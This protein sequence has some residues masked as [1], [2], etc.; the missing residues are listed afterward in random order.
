MRSGID[1]GSGDAITDAVQSS[2]AAA[3]AAAVPDA[4][5]HPANVEL[6]SSDS[7][8]QLDVSGIRPHPDGNAIV[9]VDNDKTRAVG[10]EFAQPAYSGGLP[11]APVREKEN[12]ASSSQIRTCPIPE[13]LQMQFR[14]QE[15]SD[16]GSLST[17]PWSASTTAESPRM[18][19]EARARR[20]GTVGFLGQATSDPRHSA[21]TF[22]KQPSSFRLS[23]GEF[24]PRVD[25]FA[26]P[27]ARRT[28][29][30]NSS[31]SAATPTSALSTNDTIPVSAPPQ[32]SDGGFLPE[33]E[34]ASQSLSS[35]KSRSRGRRYSVFD[36]SFAGQRAGNSVAPMDNALTV[37]QP[38]VSVAAARRRGSSRGPVDFPAYDALTATSPALRRDGAAVGIESSSILGSMGSSSNIRRNANVSRTHA[39]SLTAEMHDSHAHPPITPTQINTTYDDYA[40]RPDRHQHQ[41]LPQQQSHSSIMT[42][43]THS[44]PSDDLQCV[45]GLHTPTSER[46]ASSSALAG[47]H[48]RPGSHYYH[49]MQPTGARS[50]S[51]HESSSGHSTPTNRLFSKL[52][53]NRS[54]SVKSATA[55]DPGLARK[56]RA[57]IPSSI[58]P[59]TDAMRSPHP[60]ERPYHK[61][62]DL[63][64]GNCAY[65]FG[66]EKETEILHLKFTAS[67]PDILFMPMTYQFGGQTRA[68]K[69]PDYSYE[70]LL[71]IARSTKA[72]RWRWGHDRTQ[73][74]GR[75]DGAGS[76]TK[77]S[78]DGVELHDRSAETQAVSGMQH[79]DI[80]SSASGYHNHR[81]VSEKPESDRLLEP[82]MHRSICHHACCV[83]DPSNDVSWDDWTDRI[84]GHS[85]TAIVQR[86]VA[87]WQKLLRSWRRDHRPKSHSVYH[88]F[89]SAMGSTSETQQI[90]TPAAGA[91][92]RTHGAGGMSDV[93][94]LSPLNS[95]SVGLNP[96]LLE[97]LY[98]Q[99]GVSESGRRSSLN[100][101]AMFIHQMTGHSQLTALLSPLDKPG[102]C[103]RDLAPPSKSGD[104]LPNCDSYSDTDTPALYLPPSSSPA[105]RSTPQISLGDSSSKVPAAIHRRLSIV[106]DQE[107]GR[108]RPGLGIR[109]NSASSQLAAKSAGNSR[110]TG[111]D[112]ALGLPSKQ[113]QREPSTEGSDIPLEMLLLF[114]SRLQSRLGRAKAETE[115]ELLSII[116][117]LS[118]FVEEG[119]SYVHEDMEVGI[120]TNEGDAA[121][122]GFIFDEY[123]HASDDENV[124]TPGLTIPGKALLGEHRRAS[125]IGMHSYARNS[126]GG[127][128]S[129]NPRTHLPISPPLPVKWTS[130][131]ATARVEL[132]SLDRR[133][134]D[135]LDLHGSRSDSR[136]DI[137]PY[138]A[139][140]NAS[141]S[142]SPTDVANLGRAG[143][144]LRPSSPRKA[145]RSPSIRRLAFLKSLSTDGHASAMAASSESEHIGRREKS[146]G[147]LS[148]LPLQPQ[149]PFPEYLAAPGYPPTIAG[150]NTA[151][152]V[153]V[154]LSA[155]CSCQDT[156]MTYAQTVATQRNT[157]PCIIC[158]PKEDV[159]AAD[160]AR[161]HT[162]HSAQDDVTDYF[163][164]NLAASSQQNTEFSLPRGIPFP[165]LQKQR[166]L[167]SIASGASSHAG[168]RHSPARRSGSRASLYSTGSAVSLLSSPL[169]AED[170]FRPTPFLVAIMDLVNIIG[171]VLSLSAEDML[172]PLSGS[173]LNEALEWADRVGEE[174]E[175]VTVLMPTAYLV[176]RLNDLGYQWEHSQVASDQTH[177]GV[178]QLWPCRSLFVQALLA[179]SSLNR[180][181][182]WYQAVCSTY[183]DEDIAELDMHTNSHRDL[184]SDRGAAHSQPMDSTA[185]R[186]TPGSGSASVRTGLS[187]G[188]GSIGLPSVHGSS[189]QSSHSGFPTDASGSGKEGFGAVQNCPERQSNY[190]QRW[191]ECLG[192]PCDDKPAIDSGL[193]MLVEVALDG[194]IRY[195]SPTCRRLL[196]A[197]P[198]TMIDQPAAVMFDVRD[199]ELYRTAVEQLLTDS[200]RTVELNIRVHPPALFPVIRVEAKG[201]L[202]YG[203]LHNEPSHVLWVLRYIS[204]VSEPQSHQEHED[205]SI[206]KLEDVV[207]SEQ[208]QLIGKQN[209]CGTLPLRAV[210]AVEPLAATESADFGDADEIELRSSSSPLEPVTCRICDRNVPATHFE[211]HS[212]LCATSH[213]A[214]M[215]VEQQNERLGDIRTQLQAWFPGCEFE[216][217]EELTHGGIDTDA[218]CDKEKQKGDAVGHPAWQILVDEAA[219]I[220][221][222]MIR[223]C[224]R[225]MSLDGTDA[226]P[227]CVFRPEASGQANSDFAYSESWM[228]MVGYR[229]PVLEFSDP[230][231][232]ELGRSLLQ[233]L[234][235]KQTAVENLQYAIIDSSL[236][237]INWDGAES[238]AEE[239]MMFSDLV[240]RAAAKST[241]DLMDTLGGNRTTP[242]QHIPG[243]ASSE[244]PLR[245]STDTNT[246]CKA[247]GE[248]CYN[249][250]S[251]IRRSLSSYSLTPT[252]QR[253]VGG[254]QEASAS[255][256]D[257]VGG[258]KRMT[259]LPP[260]IQIPSRK[261]S[262]ISSRTSSAF[263]ESPDHS[264]LSRKSWQQRMAGSE[265]QPTSAR[266]PGRTSVSDASILATPT[267]PSIHDFDLLKP[268]SKGAYGSVYLAKKR[269]TGDYYAIKILKKA[270]MIAKN[271]I[272]NVKAERAIMM[273]QSG[274]PFV[275]RL[276]YT[277]QSRTSLYLVMEYLNGGDCAS[278]LKVIGVL[279]EEW[280]RHYL[281][282]VVLGIEDLHARGVVH[283]D[284]KPDNLL[285]D[286][287]GH[288][289][290]TDFGLSKLGFL[291]R[292]VGQQVMPH[293][294]GTHEPLQLSDAHSAEA[295]PDDTYPWPALAG[296]A[297][298][299]TQLRLPASIR[300]AP[301]RS[302]TTPQSRGD[303][304]NR[305]SADD[306]PQLLANKRIAALKEDYPSQSPLALEQI[307]SASGSSASISSSNSGEG[308]NGSAA[309]APAHRK[310]ALGTPD[311]IAPES[312]LGLE[313]GESVDWWALGVICYEFL[314]GVPPF[315]ECTPEK[316][317]ENILSGTI[318]FYDESR[319]KLEHETAESQ[320]AKHASAGIEKPS[321][322]DNEDQDADDEDL[323][324]PD[325]SS[326]A[327]DF[328]TRLLCRDP[329]R[330]LGYHGA[331]EV[332]AHPIFTG[333]N[334]DTLLDKQPAFIPQVE[335]VDDTD[336]FDPRGATMESDH[337]FSDENDFTEAATGCPEGSRTLS[338]SLHDNCMTP[339]LGI[340]IAIRRPKT[341][342]T[343]LD[344]VVNNVDKLSP[345][346][347]ARNNPI[348][349]NGNSDDEDLPKLDDAREFGGFT[350]KNLHALEEANMN[351]L[352]KL[353]RR[354]TLIGAPSHFVHRD[355]QRE[356][357]PV[358]MASDNS[359][360][361][362]ARRN[363]SCL[364]RSTA[365]SPSVYTE[366]YPIQR[367]SSLSRDTRQRSWSNMAGQPQPLGMES[368]SMESGTPYQQ[369]LGQSV[370]A[371]VQ[372]ART[373]TLPLISPG[374]RPLTNVNPISV[375]PVSSTLSVTDQHQMPLQPG[376]TRAASTNSNRG[377]LLNPKVQL[378]R[379]RG[380]EGQP[381]AY[382]SND[383]ALFFDSAGDQSADKDTQSWLP[384]P[385]HAP[386]FRRSATIA[387]LHHAEYSP[388][389][390]KASADG[391]KALHHS[392][393]HIKSKICLVADDN[394][395]CCKIM[396]IILQ[397]MHMGCV[398]VRNGAE[399]IRCIMGCT[400]Y[401][402]IFM[403]TGMPI[404]DGDEATRMVKS[405]YNANKDT[406][407]FAMAAYED[408]ANRALY[409]G[410]LVKPVTARQIKQLLNYRF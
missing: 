112:A 363:R 335:N 305:Y 227:Q 347:P 14:D 21:L 42:F 85:H 12:D 376:H 245:M 195:I 314:F 354:S 265:L 180:I 397:R 137:Q 325:I 159:A 192:D 289:K 310:H 317:F 95:A 101:S 28:S 403:D 184:A 396:E 40:M 2:P 22:D 402:A 356:P 146:P 332:K 197:D 336:Y 139:L 33:W 3:T 326:E 211:E 273:A 269:S 302:P 68:S 372:L 150:S 32:A 381:D 193:N 286:S 189:S 225:A 152:T 62:L 297:A 385:P 69:R 65:G 98:L 288:L 375:G 13:R 166:S 330:R 134:H 271:Q 172:C 91:A 308:G 303:V 100:D 242:S 216:Q 175:H 39:S 58:R 35:S 234:S 278:L 161:P 121:S 105:Y 182:M 255:E 361:S 229:L 76:A 103:S 86:A 109:S 324:V 337:T 254:A 393:E 248:S 221:S 214:A 19:P 300:G 312:I 52:G 320:R 379:G 11:V 143:G 408:E 240:P 133:L 224:I 233:A 34:P 169:I 268:I 198:D 18:Q 327:R 299:P 61:G 185:L 59:I 349:D 295:T 404:V 359:P 148:P 27:L 153:D 304:L 5:H 122:A 207:H 362:K 29:S 259:P 71:A 358:G 80:L 43:S 279:P 391:C 149:M 384:S 44:Q 132:R 117:D 228:K 287:E 162:W 235:D 319:E 136:E 316:V 138:S 209:T 277:F 45:S 1:N 129:S 360:L 378:V 165:S 292:R 199:I 88:C 190:P 194:R 104:T 377:S 249:Q 82:S 90:M 364:S 313:S 276:L 94:T 322:I 205:L 24:S 260:S 208:S 407:I 258:E 344:D 53:H 93:S 70:R 264:G 366:L 158:T 315:H 296:S 63:S 365:G 382:T 285:I 389:N 291:G 83:S 171:N 270:D 72:R 262:V 49:G 164:W 17:T 388:D 118:T 99:R 128:G 48:R 73:G 74:T 222:S 191:Q 263:Q 89:D 25:K 232:D 57:P 110:S 160:R 355:K 217:L 394:P 23:T 241:S 369:F 115:E 386:V 399:A 293:S 374:L 113:Q 239:P 244:T 236:A 267:V 383:D 9:D 173:L 7:Q 15:T 75:K 131:T 398:V 328:I 333:I 140:L 283:R 196:D 257:D 213:R 275:V 50:E 390:P 108:P 102:L 124:E 380:H 20:R 246:E 188:A 280:V 145:T 250:Q 230:C 135:V 51:G 237:C 218:L 392:Q 370:G 341:L 125:Q 401:R 238:L 16:Y 81:G 261:K 231:F 163:G 331:E 215:D 298:S 31:W 174:R 123:S 177:D 409:D 284:L 97:P 6:Q 272:S 274:S 294:L 252:P 306:P 329:R 96:Y 119:L 142:S 256:T 351:E 373:A 147:Q 154:G 206:N 55:T 4:N 395:I 107:L 79:E 87:M 223:I 130:E 334:W 387:S 290:L 348:D 203:R 307:N 64:D 183:S 111:G 30:N 340:G 352:L 186:N 253:G 357:S 41:H 84:S 220:I 309:A 77:E 144:N 181:V 321:G 126:A 266:T 37:P 200:T 141:R 78:N 8:L 368:G 367:G 202:I 155:T 156:I 26:M 210:S 187:E 212:W 127:G 251:P 353:R 311:Y 204:T 120:P 106:K 92:V 60:R 10:P 406:P 114:R 38:V 168:S 301:P 343:D 116:Q 410:V 167:Q 318:D 281:A 323:G 346:E 339:K 338:K 405:T 345:I 371:G 151:H 54:T 350:F 219:P 201:M 67:T 179:V 243:T 170:E 36:I 282:E 226:A 47:F 342:P 46:S 247:S 178:D 157:A 400:V 66:S 56:L 176:Q